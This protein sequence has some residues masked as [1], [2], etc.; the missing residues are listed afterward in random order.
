[1]AMSAAEARY[2]I[3]SQLQMSICLKMPDA[4]AWADDALSHEE[5]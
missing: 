1:M 4:M 5:G 3:G 2:L